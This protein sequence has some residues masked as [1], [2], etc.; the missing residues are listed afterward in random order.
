MRVAATYDLVN[1]DAGSVVTLANG[2]AYNVSGEALDEVG[3]E[4][5]AGLT[6][7]VNDNWELSLGYEGKFKK[8]KGDK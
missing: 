1:D 6:A 2:S 8:E 3:M 7:E 5:G 4:F